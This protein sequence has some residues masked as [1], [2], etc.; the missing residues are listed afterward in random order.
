[1]VFLIDWEVLRIPIWIPW[2]RYKGVSIYKRRRLWTLWTM[3]NGGGLL[4]ITLDGQRR[5][6]VDRA[7]LTRIGMDWEWFSS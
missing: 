7:G 2:H 1:M 4:D 6:G 5:G 3:R